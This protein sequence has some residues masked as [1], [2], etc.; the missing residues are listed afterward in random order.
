V[1]CFLAFFLVVVTVLYLVT[2][3]G[4]KRERERSRLEG[5]CV[6]VVYLYVTV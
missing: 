5:V 4:S 2:L 6:P 3:L 1:A